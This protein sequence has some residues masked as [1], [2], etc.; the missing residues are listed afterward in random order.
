MAVNSQKE[1][2]I[3]RLWFLLRRVGHQLS[4]SEDLVYSRYGLTSEQ[5]GVLG[6]IKSRGP[7]RPVDLASMLERGPNSMSM[8]V[9]RMVKAGLVR[10]TRDRRDRRAVFV[11]MADKGRQALAPAAPAGWEFMNKLLSPL[12]HDEQRALAS[13][14]ET[15]KCELAGY[16]NPEMDKMKIAK[17][18]FTK[19]PNLYKRLVKNIFAPGYEA[20]REGTAKRKTARGR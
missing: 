5:F 6:C 3:V 12:S 15:V 8:L 9:D 4:L 7:L 11:S 19:D 2:T 10:R 13:M 1:N 16:L 18:S 17:H 20:R 14:L